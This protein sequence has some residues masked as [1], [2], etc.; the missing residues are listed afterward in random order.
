MRVRAARAAVAAVIAGGAVVGLFARMGGAFQVKSGGVSVLNRE[1]PEMVR[2]AAGSFDMGIGDKEMGDVQ[3]S[4]IADF[5]QEATQL[6]AGQQ[7]QLALFVDAGA[8]RTPVYLYDYDID[9][10]EVTVAQYRECVD[11][12][13]C[14]LTPLVSGDTR[15][16]VDE[17]PVVNVTWGEAREYCEWRG[18]RLPTEAEWEKAARGT[19]AR[20]WPWGNVD[21]VDRANRGMAE[22]KELTL[23]GV[24]T[25][26]DDSDGSKIMAPPGSYR[27][28]KSP[29]GA[30]DMAGNVS[31]WVAD[32][33]SPQPYDTAKLSSIDPKGVTSG[34]ERTVR[35]GS[36]EDPRF[37]ARTYVRWHA[38]PNQRSITRGFRCARGG[39]PNDVI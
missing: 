7:P 28:G 39:D 29:Y 37:F 24:G 6:C 15:Y 4:C 34:T 14:D 27:W 19:D 12:G 26:T 10:Y 8:R 30:E 20:R 32:L 38:L 16:V 22:P 23:G 36:Y 2:V 3:A 33:Y 31:E 11:A 18:K 13:G 17:W 25:T 1:E 5:G 35:G 9:R 21:S